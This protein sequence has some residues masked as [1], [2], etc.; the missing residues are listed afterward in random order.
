MP[1]KGAFW[2]PDPRFQSKCH[3][4][5][6]LPQYEGRPEAPAGGRPM[7]GVEFGLAGRAGWGR[8]SGEWGRKRCQEPLFRRSSFLET[9]PDTFSRPGRLA[10]G[11]RRA[12]RCSAFFAR[13]V[14]F[15]PDKSVASA[16]LTSA[17]VGEDR[18][19]VEVEFGRQVFTNPSNVGN[20]WVFPSHFNSPSALRE[21]RL[22][23]CVPTI[24]RTPPVFSG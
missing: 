10:E 9:V 18:R 23:A 11:R 22:P 7:L 21:Y 5:T 15:Q 2:G 3:P 16:G 6:G 8:R 14:V 13:V 12:V 24:D 4:A 20:D 17:K 1:V 19:Q